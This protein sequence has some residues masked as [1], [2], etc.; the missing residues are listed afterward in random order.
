ML[1][2]FTSL[3]LLIKWG[4]TAPTRN[5]GSWVFP[6]SLLHQTSEMSLDPPPLTLHTITSSKTPKHITCKCVLSVVLGVFCIPPKHY[7]H[8]E[9]KT[10]A[11]RASGINGVRRKPSY[12]P[13]LP[14]PNLTPLTDNSVP[15]LSLGNHMLF[16]ETTRYLS[17]PENPLLWYTTHWNHHLLVLNWR[18]LPGI[19][20]AYSCPVIISSAF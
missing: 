1:F 19:S 17:A 3:R 18:I 6:E 11:F 12:A 20:H 13:S 9:F 5:N 15:A 8:I 4:N 7:L 14:Q 16:E 2:P 10:L